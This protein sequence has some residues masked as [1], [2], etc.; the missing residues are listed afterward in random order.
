MCSTAP[1]AAWAGSAL[2][3]CIISLHPA[4]D[5]WPEHPGGLHGEHRHDDEQRDRELEFPAD[6]G[7]ESA[8]EIFDHADSESAEHRAARA[9][10]P[11]EHGARKAV[12]QDAS[13]H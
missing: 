11:A 3:S 1:G 9:G 4:D 10:E 13:H 12:E 2:V 7:N 8:G 6:I 5:S